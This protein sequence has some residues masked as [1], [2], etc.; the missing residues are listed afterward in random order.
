MLGT[1]VTGQG[2]KLLTMLGSGELYIETISARD[3]A[4]ARDPKK[5]IMKP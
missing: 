2:A 4:V 3:A 1:Y 5:Q